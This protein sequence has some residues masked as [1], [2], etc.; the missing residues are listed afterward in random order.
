[1]DIFTSNGGLR[2][3]FLSASYIVREKEKGPSE[4]RWLKT[5]LSSGT[6]KDKMAARTLLIQVPSDHVQLSCELKHFG[7]PV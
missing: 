1:M 7:I 6:L 5:V 3:P 4:V 2:N